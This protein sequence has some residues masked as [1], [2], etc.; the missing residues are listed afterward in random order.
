MGK[1][2][3]FA[4]AAGVLGALLW[5]AIAY[6]ADMEIGLLAWAIGAAVGFAMLMGAEDKVG[7]NTGI[8]AVVIASITI[9]AGKFLSV[10]FAIQSE[11]N[12]ILVDQE[13]RLDS[14]D[15]FAITYVADDIL[16]EYEEANRP[17]DFPLNANIDSPESSADY[18]VN[19]WAEAD[20]RWQAM[21]DA[22]KEQVRQKA[23]ENAEEAMA[24]IADLARKEGFKSSFSFF[25]ILWFAFGGFSA[26]KIGSGISNES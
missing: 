22:D 23:T 1:G 25:D 14:D 12:Q 15:Q 2:I 13:Q 9:L 6:F 16:F 24:S 4:I 5:A 20:E 3:G 21:T 17:L 18:P 8:A 7:L 11:I 10:E 26:F 19:V